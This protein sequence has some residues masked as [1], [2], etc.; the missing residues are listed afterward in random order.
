MEY[1]KL[2]QA[3]AREVGGKLEGKGSYVVR[4]AS[5]DKLFPAGH[6]EGSASIQKGAIANVDM[7]Q[8]LQGA[9]SAGGSTPFSE[10]SGNF[11]A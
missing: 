6:I 11:S 1:V 9:G 5:P 4:A 2:E 3:E 8:I 7:K 10:V